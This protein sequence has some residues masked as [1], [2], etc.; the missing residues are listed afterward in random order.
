MQFNTSFSHQRHI[1]KRQ[2][3]L[4]INKSS[5]RS[6]VWFPIVNSSL[7]KIIQIYEKI[8]SFL[9]YSSETINIIIPS[10]KCIL[11]IFYM[12]YWWAHLFLLIHPLMYVVQFDT[13]LI[14]CSFLWW[15]APWS[16][17]QQTGCLTSYNNS[18]TIYVKHSRDKGK[19]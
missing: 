10:L 11:R 14:Y 9:P 16:K 1:E 3:L 5:T 15:N 12:L 7:A 18:L 17:A 6:M 13:R 19:N 4:I 8:S 2:Y